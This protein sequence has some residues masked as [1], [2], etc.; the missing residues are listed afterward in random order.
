MDTLLH[1]REV[2]RRG[3]LGAGDLVEGGVE[4]EPR[5]ADLPQAG[6]LL[7]HRYRAVQQDAVADEVLGREVWQAGAVL[8]EEVEADRARPLGD[9]PLRGLGGEVRRAG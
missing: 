1:D 5:A 4:V 3:A 8:L 7:Q 2:A 9:Q 6:N